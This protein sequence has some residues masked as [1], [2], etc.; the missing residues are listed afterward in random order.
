MKSRV[1][2]AAQ[3]Q[4]DMGNRLPVRLAFWLLDRPRL[5]HHST[6]KRFAG[7][8]LKQPARKGVVAAQSRLG[9]LLCR[10]C[11][12]ARDRRIGQELLRQAARAGDL[13]AQLELGRLYCQPRQRE[14]LQARHWLELAAAQGSHEAARLLQRLDH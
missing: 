8:L 9:Q 14:P 6:I 10:D 4:P 2:S 11:G 13:R 3:H 7:G 1:L 5:G 12:N